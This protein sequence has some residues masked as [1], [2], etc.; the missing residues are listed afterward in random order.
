[1]AYIGLRVVFGYEHAMFENIM[2][3]S[4]DVFSNAGILLLLSMSLLILVAKPLTKEI[5]VF[6]IASLA[7]VLPVLLVASPCEIRLWTPLILLF[8]ILKVRAS[9]LPV[10]SAERQLIAN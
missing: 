7:Y 2:T 10:S 9:P 4:Y 3:S 5:L 6:F 8:T 1:L